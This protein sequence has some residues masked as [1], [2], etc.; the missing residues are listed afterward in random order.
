[1]TPRP[2]SAHIV[3]TSALLAFFNSNEPRHADVSAVIESAPTGRLVVSPYA[4]AELDYLVA[5]RLGVQAELAV[6]EELASGAWDCAS[7]GPQ[8]LRDIGSILRRYDD[9]QIGVADAS[10][11]HLA[12]RY[13]TRVVVTLNRRQFSTLRPK[14]GGR[15]T[16]L[17]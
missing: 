2:A 8:D 1:V 10:L 6:L 3:D 7:L 4:I 11:V 16:V 9:Q 17:P 14:S 15:F 13:R 12:D 5:T